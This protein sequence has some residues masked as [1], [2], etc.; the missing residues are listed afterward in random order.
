MDFSSEHKIVDLKNRI[1]AS[2]VIWRRKMNAKDGK[3]TWGSAVSFE[4]REIFEERAE[5]VLLIL[6]Q[7]FPGIPQSTLDI[8]KIQYNR[9]RS[10][11]LQHLLSKF[12]IL[13]NLDFLRLSIFYSLFLVLFHSFY[14]GYTWLN[15][16]LQYYRGSSSW[17]S[18]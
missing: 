7:R 12:H 6:K 10:C 1:E 16:E 13:E 14:F 5:L 18:T 3:S 9:V 8:S 4:K 15:K 2:V 17:T 11:M